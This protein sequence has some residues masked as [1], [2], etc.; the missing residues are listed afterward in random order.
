MRTKTLILITVI[1]VCGCDKNNLPQPVKEDKENV[2]MDNMEMVLHQIMKQCQN[3]D[4]QS[5]ES[6]FQ[7]LH[8]PGFLSQLDALEVY[9]DHLDPPTLL[10]I[11]QCL[12]ENHNQPVVV[13]G[14]GKLADSPLYARNDAKGTLR[15]NVLIAASGHLT[16][17]DKKILTFLEKEVVIDGEKRSAAVYALSKIGTSESLAILSKHVFNPQTC[18]IPENLREIYLPNF[19]MEMAEFRDRPAVLSFLMDQLY[20]TEPR[21]EVLVGLIED[22]IERSPEHK[23]HIHA[24]PLNR[25]TANSVVLAKLIAVWLIQNSTDLEEYQYVPIA[26]RVP[27]LLGIENAPTPPQEG[28]AIKKWAA[29]LFQQAWKQSDDPERKQQLQLSLA[30]FQ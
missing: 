6:M 25:E 30:A 29:S 23:Y 10:K 7:K 26:R 13:V 20:R 28:L 17:P 22:R 14:L 21:S 24:A 2:K 15:R 5:L 9:N 18:V 4:S 1:L 16:Q 11:L 27:D 19:T 3:T 8:N 12:T